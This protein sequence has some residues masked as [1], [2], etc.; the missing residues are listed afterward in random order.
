MRTATVVLL[1]ALGAFNLA[2]EEAQKPPA[3]QSVRIT[4]EALGD[5]DA[6]VVTRVTVSFPEL[7]QS[8]GVPIELQG[9]IL[10]QAIVVRNFRY[11]VPPE[12]KS[13][14]FVQTFPAGEVELDIHILTP[15]GD[16]TPLIVGKATA[17]ITIAAT[18]KPYVASEDA[19]AEAIF[20]EG[21]VPE[22]AGSVKIEPPRRD[23]APNLFVVDVDVKPPVKKVEFWVEGKKIFTKNAPPYHAELDLGKIP[24]RVDVTVIGYDAKGRYI[25]ADSWVVNE[26]DNPV[27]AKLTRNVTPDGLSHFKVS[28]QNNQGSAIA[29]VALEANGKRIA[30]WT[31][32][33]Y[34]LSIPAAR[35]EGAGF[36]TALVLDAEGKELASDLVFLDGSRYSEEISVNLIELPVTV[37]DKNGAVISDLKQEDFQVLEQGKPVKLSSF[38]FASNLPL[39]LG[40]LVDHS[41]SMLPRIEQTRA[42]ALQFFKKMIGPADR[43]FFGGFSWETQHVSPFLSD[44]DALNAQV[45][46]MP[47]PEG[48]TALYDSVVTGLYK[49]RTIPGRKALVIVT[50][51]ED[52]VSRLS[53][54]DMLAY[55]R[56]ARVPVYFIGIGMSSL[57]TSGIRSLSAETGAVTYLIKDVAQLDET[58]TKLEKDLRSQYLLAYYA[59]T[60]KND[61]AYRSIEVRVKREGAVV[62]TIRGYIP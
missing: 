12:S 29:K 19:G 22:T 40:V 52:T 28:V 24:R 47:K 57:G 26:R 62:R 15:T 61:S 21:V 13:F 45:D 50:D 58:Y 36:V 51:G 31:H 16:D 2:A 56:T 37:V 11:K 33:P 53:Y 8:G 3:E 18:G 27:E 39:S 4:S 5:A 44:L 46:A 9:S 25:D 48:G 1:L 20:A 17:K 54:Q 42:A 7:D 34:A 35:L 43:A 32:P 14:S 30:E 60:A 59:Q 10:Q 6:G 38:G 41:G 55:V 49:F 23:L